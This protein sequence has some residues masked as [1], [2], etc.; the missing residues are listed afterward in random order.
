M[1][2]HKE[3]DEFNF[4][5]RN[6]KKVLPWKVQPVK[7]YVIK[8]TTAN[9]IVLDG[10]ILLMDSKTRKPL[11]FGTLGIHKKT[12]FQEANVSTFNPVGYHYYYYYYLFLLS[13][14]SPA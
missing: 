14:P 11:P 3:G 12:Q 2:I 6:L 4:F 5:S 9:S 10:E 13:T 1:Q 7:E 8:A